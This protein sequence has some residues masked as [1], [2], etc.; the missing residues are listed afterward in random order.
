MY[1][2]VFVVCLVNLQRSLLSAVR[3]SSREN[4][5]YNNCFVLQYI[6][7]YYITLCCVVLTGLIADRPPIISCHCFAFHTHLSRTFLHTIAQCHSVH[8]SASSSCRAEQLDPGSL[9][10][11]DGVYL[12]SQ[13]LSLEDL[14]YYGAKKRA[15]SKPES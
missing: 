7:L 2:V 6:L 5:R 10:H 12:V 8:F 4:Y 3:L 9:P 14:F 15:H 11:Q 1:E 13:A